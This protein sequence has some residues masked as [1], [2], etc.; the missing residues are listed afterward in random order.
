MDLPSGELSTGLHLDPMLV[1]FGRQTSFMDARDDEPS[2]SRY[3][4]PVEQSAVSGSTLSLP[5]NPQ[6][7][8]VT[9]FCLGTS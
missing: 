1:T 7:T 4:T 6:V 5:I 2:V 8:K 3:L 9:L